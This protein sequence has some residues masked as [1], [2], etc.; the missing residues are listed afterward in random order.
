MEIPKLNNSVPL[1]LRFRKLGEQR[2]PTH[3]RELGW[4]FVL[5]CVGLVVVGL[6]GLSGKP[7]VLQEQA[8]SDL[9]VFVR[10]GCPHCEKAKTYL[11]RLKKRYPQLTVTVRDIGED[12]PALLRLKTLAAKF[13]ITQLGVPA[14]FGRGELLVGFDSEVT[15]GKQLE[16]LLGRPPPD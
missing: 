2:S 13:G 11:T 8:E 12:P 10:Q 7:D 6:L 15:T 3:L 1:S 5:L 9:E 14:F 16:Q 4:P